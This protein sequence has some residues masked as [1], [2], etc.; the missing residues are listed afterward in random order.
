MPR[1]EAPRQLL[2]QIKFG[3]PEGNRT[4]I[5]RMQTGCSATKLR[6]LTTP[7]ETKKLSEKKKV[8][9]PFPFFKPGN[10]SPESFFKFDGWRVAKP[11]FGLADVRVSVTN[12]ADARR[13]MLQT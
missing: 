13:A 2:R 12:V 9:L 10:R 3:G 8:C 5:F 4:P 11:L 6:A 7:L 1:G